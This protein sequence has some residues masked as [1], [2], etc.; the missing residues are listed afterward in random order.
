MKSAAGPENP[1][2]FFKDLVRVFDMLEYVEYPDEVE[3][4]IGEGQPFGSRHPEVHASAR[5]P[6]R[7]EGR[8]ADIAAKHLEI[9]PIAFDRLGHRPGSTS[10]IEN[11]TANARQV[12][13]QVAQLQAVHVPGART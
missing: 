4:T 13:Q 8:F 1:H 11:P 9:R 5:L 3:L 6:G 12:G 10:D 7:R 2:N